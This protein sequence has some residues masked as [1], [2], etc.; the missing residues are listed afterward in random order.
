ME[1]YKIVLRKSVFKDF[2]SIPKKDIKKILEKIKLLEKDPK[3]RVCEKLS[4]NEK[5]RIR[6]GDYRILYLVE[7]SIITVTIVKVGYR[8]SVYS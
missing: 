7:D 1:F 5:Y 6:C 3:S 8:K 2:R 4:G